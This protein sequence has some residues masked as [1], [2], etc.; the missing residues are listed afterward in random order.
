MKQIL[1]A[2]IVITL[3]LAAQ[4]AWAEAPSDPN[5]WATAT[6]IGPDQGSPAGDYSM[7]WS[8]VP[9]ANWPAGWLLV[10]VEFSPDGNNPTNL[11]STDQPAT[12][13]NELYSTSGPWLAWYANGTGVQSNLTNANG[14]LPATAATEQWCGGFT[15]SGAINDYNYHLVFVNSDGGANPN[16]KWEIVQSS[17]TA[18]PVPEPGTLALLGTGLAGLTG[19]VIRRRRSK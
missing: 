11:V 12:W 2:V 18:T 5:T 13:N 16:G 10:G 7:C 14:L 19:I 4:A 15:V 1:I 6:V 3:L 8:V 17:L 9:T